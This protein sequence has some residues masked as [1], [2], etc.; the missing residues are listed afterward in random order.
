MDIAQKS[1][2][3]DQDIKEFMKK[4]NGKIKTDT[5]KPIK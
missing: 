4:F 3:E 1:I 5:I 2:Y